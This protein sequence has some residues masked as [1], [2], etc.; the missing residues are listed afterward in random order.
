MARYFNPRVQAFDSDG[1]AN[2]TAQ[3]FFFAKGTTTLQATFQ[4]DA[5]TIP[6]QNPVTPDKDS[7][8]PDIFLQNLD[9]TV[10]YQVTDPD[11]GDFEQQW[12]TDISGTNIATATESS[13]GIVQLATSAQVAAGT[14]V[15][16]V[17]AQ[18]I[19]NMA[20]SASQITGVLASANL[21]A[22]TTTAIGAV[23]A[24]TQTE[25]DNGTAGK[26]PDCAVI[27]T[28]VDAQVS[29]GGAGVFDN[30]SIRVA[31]TKTDTVSVAEGTGFL[32]QT[33][34][35]RPTGSFAT[36]LRNV[37]SGAENRT[38]RLRFQKIQWSSD[39]SVFN[40]AVDQ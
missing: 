39:G 8:F 37:G 22:A 32:E 6:N 34:G 26:F 24:A 18:Y 25:M 2:E 30:F 33:T 21:P 1:V 29:G 10:R 5:L 9:Y 7:F 14:G 20:I 38:D 13:E 4:D 23:E 36:D 17:T 31:S 15:N 11:S 19:A 40:D 27:K 16:V 28:F 35:G 3:L 12:S